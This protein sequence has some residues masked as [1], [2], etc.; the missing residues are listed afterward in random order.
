MRV[1]NVVMCGSAQIVRNVYTRL[2]P[3]IDESDVMELTVSVDGSWLTRVTVL[4]MA[5]DVLWRW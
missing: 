4:S 2:D 5:L 1:V 3:S